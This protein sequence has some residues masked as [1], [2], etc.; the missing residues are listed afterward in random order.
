MVHL[1]KNLQNKSI[2][3]T[4]CKYMMDTYKLISRFR[5]LLNNLTW[6]VGNTTTINNERAKG[7]LNSKTQVQDR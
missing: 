6:Y 7:P 3:E 2:G 5:A 1:D 4:M